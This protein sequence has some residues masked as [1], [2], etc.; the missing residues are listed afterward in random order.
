MRTPQH[1]SRSHGVA[2]SP[3]Y[4]T[5]WAVLAAVALA[6][7]ALLVVKP[8]LAERLIPSPSFGAPED[9]R[10][11]RALARAMTELKEMREVLVTVEREL[12]ELR[13]TVTAGDTRDVAL[14]GRVAALETMLKDLSKVDAARPTTPV[15]GGETADPATP[16]VLGYVEERPTKALRDA[17]R[18]AD[19]ARAATTV[20][21]PA[22]GPLA[23]PAPVPAPS[24]AAGPQLGIELASGPS[25]DALRLSW[26][27][28]QDSH[29]AAVKALEPRVIETPGDPPSYRLI[30]GPVASETEGDKL[31][32]RLRQR[33]LTCSVQPF[34][35]K[36]L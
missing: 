16:R 21:A 30:A 11:Q 17:P 26:Q 4:L 2:L 24:K 13:K 8:E 25:L 15:A 23:T 10:G 33:R 14:A 35:G 32:T 7:L 29:K 34:T 18:P 5:V 3:R 36:P 6:Y 9:N 1:S 19:T 28:M 22:P 20:I 12:G 27:L 31:C